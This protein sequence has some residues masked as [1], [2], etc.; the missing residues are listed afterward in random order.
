MSRLIFLDV[1]RNKI[2]ACD[3]N[4][5][6]HLQVPTLA[7]AGTTT[8]INK[9]DNVCSECNKAFTRRKLLNRHIRTLHAAHNPNT[10][11]VFFEPIF[12]SVNV[13]IIFFPK[14]KLLRK[15]KYICCRSVV[16]D[17]VALRSL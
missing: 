15:I 8:N 10:C 2:E 16:D 9:E 6:E 12:V 3:D 4:Q 17:V 1:L 14:V 11:K 5:L 13:A 7:H